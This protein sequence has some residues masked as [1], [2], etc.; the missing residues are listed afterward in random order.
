MEWDLFC[1]VVDNFGDI[2]VC[3]RLARQLARRGESVR[4]W[5]DDASALRWMAPEPAPGLAVLPWAA[6]GRAQP[7]DVVIE[8]FGCDPDEPFRQAMASRSPAPIWINLE[9]LSAEPYVERSHGLP[10]P[11][12][13]GPGAGLTKWFFYPGFNQ[14]TGGLLREPELEAV[15]ARYR[16]ATWLA[17]KG[18]QRREGERLIS[19]FCYDNPALR[20]LLGPLSQAPSCLLLTQG[21]AQQQMSE[22]ALPPNLRTVALPWLNHGDFDLLLWTCDLN[23]VRGE[24]SFVRAHWAGKPMVWQIYPQHDGAHVAKLNAWL[25]THTATF[26][27]ALAAQVRQLHGI[28]NGLL[29]G[30]AQLPDLPDWAQHCTGTRTKL[31]KQL[32]LCEQLL[33]FVAQKRP[34]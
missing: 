5:V 8:A 15:M 33:H 13:N 21:P 3:H 27:P 31:L 17:S 4:L 20:T 29:P 18:I 2:A 19:L 9:Y 34:R 28:W 10:S 12:M 32:D 6:Q 14:Y 1:R 26:E 24:D 23:F 7:A 25:D 11:V 22:L 16:A 30:P